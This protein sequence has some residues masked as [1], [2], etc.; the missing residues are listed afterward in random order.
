MHEITHYVASAE[1]KGWKEDMWHKA[2]PFGELTVRKMVRET[3][4]VGG[5]S[6]VLRRQNLLCTEGPGGGRQK[7]GC[8]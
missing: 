3:V 1:L 7:P 4:Q 5:M 8:S 6:I 2:P